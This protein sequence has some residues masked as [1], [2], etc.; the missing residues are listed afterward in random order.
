A[1]AYGTRIKGLA[2]AI[3]AA[4]TGIAC[5]QELY[6]SRA[7]QIYGADANPKPQLAPSRRDRVRF[8][9]SGTRGRQGL[10]ASPLHPEGPG[11]VT[12]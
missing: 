9:R 1:P 12:R 3:L 4:T 5:G 6:P 11:N 2:A 8:H 7:N 10:G